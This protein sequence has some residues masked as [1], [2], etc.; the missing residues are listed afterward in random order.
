MFRS[1]KSPQ[2]HQE[3]KEAVIQQPQPAMQ[4][5]PITIKEEKFM[6]HPQSVNKEESY[7]SEDVVIQGD[8]ECSGG[9]TLLGTIRGNVHCGKD[10]IV[11]GQITG[12]VSADNLE[13][14][15]GQIEGNVQCRSTLTMDRDCVIRGD[16]QASECVTDGEIYGSMTI[17]GNLH[18][19]K[20]A[21]IEGDIT[22]RQFSVLQGAHL[23]SK[24]V[25]LQE[26]S[27]DTEPEE[28][29]DMDEDGEFD[30]ED[31]ASQEENELQ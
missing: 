23:E 4:P 18:V 2:P 13:L 31:A 9:L 11:R 5:A 21:W 12:N 16:V 29:D 25:M 22:A 27:E 15:S 3:E 28:A 19:Q 6:D 8:V 10:L 1:R 24:I 14:H 17:E 20:N 30:E 26:E 7:L